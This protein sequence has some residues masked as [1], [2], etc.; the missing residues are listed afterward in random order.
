MLKKLIT[1][2]KTLLIALILVAVVIF[3][4]VMVRQNSD[5]SGKI[6]AG[7][8]TENMKEDTDENKEPYDGTGLEVMDEMD[9]TVDCVDAAGDWDESSDVDNQSE[10]DNKKENSQSNTSEKTDDN[11]DDADEEPNE[12]ILVD[13]KEWGEPS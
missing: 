10:Q 5:E 2:K 7:V 1:N 3:I 13:D 8:D 9:D 6:G 12:N 11:N 4:T